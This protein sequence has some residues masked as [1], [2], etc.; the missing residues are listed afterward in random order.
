MVAEHDETLGE[1]S[2]FERIGSGKFAGL[3][4]V[5]WVKTNIRFHVGDVD[6]VALDVLL[7]IRTLSV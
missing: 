5:V 6:A 7:E 3:V 4:I 2:T 1:G